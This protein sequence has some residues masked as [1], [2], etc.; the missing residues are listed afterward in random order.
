MQKLTNIVAA[1][2]IWKEEAFEFRRRCCFV[3]SIFMSWTWIQPLALSVIFRFLLPKS[4]G[5]SLSLSL[6]LSLSSF[7]VSSP[8][9]TL[10]AQWRHCFNSIAGTQTP[11]STMT[12]AI[13]VLLRYPFF[14]FS[15]SL[16][17]PPSFFGL[18]EKLKK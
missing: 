2:N 9:D 5:I 8:F 12:M 15:F 13:I 17:T 4:N 6:S 3:S 16:F 18:S 10:H 11:T 7:F 14:S 1:V